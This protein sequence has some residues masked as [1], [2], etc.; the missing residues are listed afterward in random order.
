MSSSLE[1]GSQLREPSE[2]SNYEIIRPDDAGIGGLLSCSQLRRSIR[3]EKVLPLLRNPANEIITRGALRRLLHFLSRFLK[4]GGII[5]RGLRKW[6]EHTESSPF[7]SFFLFFN[8]SL[9]PLL[10]QV[11]FIIFA[12]ELPAS[13][14]ARPRNLERSALAQE[15]CFLSFFFFSPLFSLLATFSRSSPREKYVPG[16][17]RGLSAGLYERR[18]EGGDRRGVCSSGI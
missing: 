8:L 5:R 7:F 18:G 12:G 13:G 14:D 17:E 11:A 4:L 10:W 6:P 2:R 15:R 1:R 3:N 9:H 16:A